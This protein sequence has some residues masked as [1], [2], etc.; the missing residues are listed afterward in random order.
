[1][2]KKK[3]LFIVRKYISAFSARHAIDLDKKS[4][5]DDVWVDDEWKKN[6]I[7]QM[8]PAIGFLTDNNEEDD[9]D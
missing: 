2:K 8:Q 3:K 5:V 7:N 4:P 9:N 6:N 1:M